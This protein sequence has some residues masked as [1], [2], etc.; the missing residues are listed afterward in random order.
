MQPVVLSR[1]TSLMVPTSWPSAERTVEPITLL[2]GMKLPVVV[3]VLV[4]ELCA[5]L[6]DGAR[7]RP[8]RASTA[9]SN[10]DF[11]IVVKD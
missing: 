2:V 7:A 5:W 8:A 11:F 4:V 10:M 3:V 1:T 6:V 9:P